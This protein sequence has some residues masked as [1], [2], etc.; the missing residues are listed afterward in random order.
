MEKCETCKFW[1]AGPIFKEGLG[2]EDG[3]GYCRLRDPQ[4]G[5]ATRWPVTRETEWCGMYLASEPPALPDWMEP[6][7]PRQEGVTAR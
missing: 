2:F 3:T 6:F 7:V 5:F 1:S 4:M